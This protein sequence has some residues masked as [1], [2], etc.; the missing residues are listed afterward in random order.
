VSTLP[1]PLRFALRELRGGLSGFYVLI[2]CITLGVAAIAGVNSVSRALTEGVRAEGRV[3]LGGDLAFSLDF[4]RGKPRGAGVPGKQGQVGEIATM[5]AMVRSRTGTGRRWS[6][7]RRW[8]TLTRIAADWRSKGRKEEPLGPRAMAALL[9]SGDG[10]P[11][12]SRR[13]SFWIDLARRWATVS[14][15]VQASSRSAA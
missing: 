1:V 4:A 7:S 13:R 6:S 3:I 15:S 11:A 2:A 9:A 12:H 5:R 10:I 8:T 14:S